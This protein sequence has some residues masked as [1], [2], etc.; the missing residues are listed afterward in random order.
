[1]G[2]SAYGY[3]S[4]HAP[5]NRQVFGELTRQFAAM[6]EL[7][8]AAGEPDPAADPRRVMALYQQWLRTRD[9]ALADRLRRF[10]IQSAIH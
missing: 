8:S 7:V 3:L 5:G 10:G 9:P 4:E 6:L 2:S 1:M